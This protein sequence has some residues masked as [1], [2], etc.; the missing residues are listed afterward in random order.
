VT[1]IG[2]KQKQNE[3]KPAK[4]KQK[5]VESH[6]ILWYTVFMAETYFE[7]RFCTSCKTGLSYCG[8]QQAPGV[9]LDA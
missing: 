3:Q 9:L 6:L 8:H 2:S 4:I 1:V 7:N 5:Q